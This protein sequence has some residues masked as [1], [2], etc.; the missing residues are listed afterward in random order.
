MQSWITIDNLPSQDKH[1]YDVE[2]VVHELSLSPA[3]LCSDPP[4]YMSIN[5]ALWPYSSLELPIMGL[6]SASKVHDTFTCLNAEALTLLSVVPN[7]YLLH[8][9]FVIVIFIEHPR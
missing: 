1:E 7:S 8:F 2:I 5:P 9:S 6:P 3:L 4:S